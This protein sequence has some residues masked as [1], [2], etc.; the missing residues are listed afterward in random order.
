MMS[1]TSADGI[2]IAAIQ[3]DD[4]PK[5]HV[6]ILPRRAHYDYSPELREQ[7]LRAAAGETMTAYELAA[8]HGAL[9]DA[10]ATAACDFIPGLGTKPVRWPSDRPASCPACG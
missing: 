2:D 9:G 8:L 1:G 4:A 5:P 7:V 3:I 6:R 10:Y